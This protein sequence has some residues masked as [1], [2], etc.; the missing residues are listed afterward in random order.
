VLA[1]ASRSIRDEVH[2]IIKHHGEFEIVGEVTSLS[3]IHDSAR[4]FHPDILLLCIEAAPNDS[5]QAIDGVLSA[6]EETK[7]IAVTGDFSP[8]DLVRMMR[9]GM[10]GYIPG[11]ALSDHFRI[12]I[13][14]VLSDKLYFASRTVGSP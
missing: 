6:S 11:D 5:I 12:A 4:D 9:A 1:R 7:I 10:H 2:Q 8:R 13:R 3:S 14:T